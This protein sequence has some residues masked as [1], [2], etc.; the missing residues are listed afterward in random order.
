MSGNFL[1]ERRVPLLRV[2]GK[3]QEADQA[4]HHLGGFRFGKIA[5]VL[6]LDDLAG[7]AGRFGPDLGIKVTH[8]GIGLVVFRLHHPS[9]VAGNNGVFTPFS[10]RAGRSAKSARRERRKLDAERYA[11]AARNGGCPQHVLSPP[12]IG[13]SETERRPTN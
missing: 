11:A 1:A 9:P 3:V 4:L 2:G 12:W 13:R 6:A 7:G 5:A 8:G 10:R